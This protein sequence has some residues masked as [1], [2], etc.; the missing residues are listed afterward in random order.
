M[1]FF[2]SGWGKQTLFLVLHD[3]QVILSPTS[4]WVDYSHACT[5]QYSAEYSVGAL[6]LYTEFSLCEDLSSLFLWP[7][8]SKLWTCPNSQLHLVN[9]RSLP[10]YK[11]V[12]PLSI[13]AKIPSQRVSWGN[14]RAHFTLSPLSGNTAFVT[15]SQVSQQL[16]FHI[17]C[18]FIFLPCFR[19][20]GKSTP[21]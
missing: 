12:P 1:W 16:L 11:W 8:K 15:W 20:E 5:N 3:Y 21:C 4:L 13:I 19:Q 6:C 7:V 18:L 2:Q 17:F 10:R 14:Q 9:S